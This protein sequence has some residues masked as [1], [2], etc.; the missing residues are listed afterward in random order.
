MLEEEDPLLCE[1]TPR[2]LSGT[3]L[4]IAGPATAL[5]APSAAERSGWSAEKKGFIEEA[6]AVCA[7]MQAR[8]RDANDISAALIHGLKELSSLR[9]PAGEEKDVDRILKN[10]RDLA[11]AADA[12]TD[13][14]GED[15]LPAAVGV[16]EFAKRFNSAASRYGL[17][18]CAT[19]G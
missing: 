19:L 14:E 13:D 7:E 4:T 2:C 3:M 8:M 1:A 9:A 16:G 11:R 10:L 12:L 17:E 6:N 18:V 5:P 15:A